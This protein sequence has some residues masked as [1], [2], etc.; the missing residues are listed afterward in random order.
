MKIILTQDNILNL[1]FNNLM[2]ASILDS[3]VELINKI[4]K[5]IEE[6]GELSQAF[7]ALANTGNK[8][9]SA[10]TIQEEAIDV[11][12]V[13]L[14]IALML[15]KH[16]SEFLTI[17]LTDAFL[18]G[19]DY[20]NDINFDLMQPKDVFYLV[21]TIQNEITKIHELFESMDKVDRTKEDY[22]EEIAEILNAAVKSLILIMGDAISVILISGI[23]N[24]ELNLLF[25][26]KTTKWL[27]KSE[28]NHTV[29]G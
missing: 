11:L 21:F 4:L 17:F 2:E 28:A 8:S 10:S 19:S 29:G 18:I 14:D 7:L 23:D 16:Q 24:E 25:N 27:S 3:D 6:N 9:K 1:N 15:V 20:F 12:S 22:Q 13:A 26:E 5:L